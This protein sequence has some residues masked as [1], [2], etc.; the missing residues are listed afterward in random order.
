[1]EFVASMLTLNYP[2]ENQGI[3]M[4]LFCIQIVFTIFLLFSLSQVSDGRQNDTGLQISGR[5]T[6]SLMSFPSITIPLYLLYTYKDESVF[7][8]FSSS[9]I[10]CVIP[11]LIHHFHRGLIYPFLMKGS[12]IQV[13][14][15][16]LGTAYSTMDS[17]LQNKYVLSLSNSSMSSLSMLRYAVGITIFFIGLFINL[18]ADYSLIKLSKNRKKGQYIIPRGFMFEYIS[19]PNFFGETVEW[20]G[21]AICVWTL[22]G[23]GLFIQTFFTLIPRGTNRHQYYKKKF[24]DYPPNRKAVI[25]FIL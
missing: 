9:K 23:W 3:L 16:L 11:F 19:S 20:L 10:L 21:Y 17:Y 15:T 4:T 5:I 18:Q 6:M 12:T 8:T 14:V 7:L 24:S 25:P 1:M 13:F 2:V 22:C